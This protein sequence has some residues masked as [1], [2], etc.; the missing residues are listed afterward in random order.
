M[1]EYEKSDHDL[2]AFYYPLVASHM[3][4][5]K[6]IDTRNGSGVFGFAH[7]QQVFKVV[8]SP[9]LS[10]LIKEAKNIL[11][12]DYCANDITIGVTADGDDDLVLKEGDEFIE[13]QD[14]TLKNFYVEY[15]QKLEASQATGL[16]L[17]LVKE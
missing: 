14:R 2:F 7:K 6:L 9:F 1:A 4:M 5:I 10:E 16:V 13:D 17:V 12:K 11:A 15:Y 8:F 3:F